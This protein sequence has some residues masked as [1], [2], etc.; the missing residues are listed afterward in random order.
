[1]GNNMSDQKYHSQ[2]HRRRPQ[3]GRVVLNRRGR[4]LNNTPHHPSTTPQEGTKPVDDLTAGFANK[5]VLISENDPNFTMLDQGSF[6]IIK[7]N[8]PNTK[9]D[10]TTP[11]IGA[12]KKAIKSKIISKKQID[13]KPSLSSQSAK[14]AS[15]QVAKTGDNATKKDDNP[16]FDQADATVIPLRIKNRNIP[17]DVPRE[18]PI[19]A[20][21]KPLADDMTAISQADQRDDVCHQA[22]TE[23]AQEVIEK[24]PQ[25]PAAETAPITDDPR[26]RDAKSPDSE[27]PSLPAPSFS[28]S[29][30]QILRNWHIGAEIGATINAIVADELGQQVRRITRSV[31][32][33]MVRDGTLDLGQ[34]T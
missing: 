32:Q 7:A 17:A 8:K 25:Y 23:I 21:A 9:K 1:M 15:L 12:E 13:K 16:I 22:D 34:K 10:N 30:D 5:S 28:A 14:N 3:T 27:R 24:S 29:D 20:S 18:Y 33:D 31:I 4:I 19:A 6:M 2:S 26:S 11:L